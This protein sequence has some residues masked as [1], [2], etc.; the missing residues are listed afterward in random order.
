MSRRIPSSLLVLFIVILSVGFACTKG[1]KDKKEEKTT[2]GQSATET[3]VEEETLQADNKDDSN[4]GRILAGYYK[5]IGGPEKWQEVKTLKYTG[6]IDSLGRTLKLAFVYKRPNMCRLDFGLNNF[7]FIQ[8]YDGEQGWK[9]NLTSPGSEPVPL[10]G[11]ELDDLIETCDFDGPLIDHEKKGHKIEYMG[12]EKKEGK[13]AYKLKI[14][15]NTAN[16]DY[17]YLDTHI[18]LPF[19]VEGTAD[20]DGERKNTVTKIGRYIET[21]GLNLP[22]DFEYI[23]EGKDETDVLKIST[24][25]INGEFDDT[26]FRFP[27]RPGESY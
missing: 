15:F 14:T 9:Y 11:E 25:E 21:G 17:Y 2:D 4:L 27:H 13:D 23:I 18:Y 8:A 20:V 5:A 12:E 7:Y 24:V 3:A 22:Y 10:A 19:L 1:E 26:I 6:T 16:V